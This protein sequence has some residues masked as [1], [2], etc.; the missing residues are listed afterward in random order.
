MARR[1][2]DLVLTYCI[3][4]MTKACL[5]RALRILSMMVVQVVASTSC[6]QIDGTMHVLVLEV[7][8]GRKVLLWKMLAW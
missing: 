2:L 8:G 3:L 1:I 5:D 7:L 4:H 6:I